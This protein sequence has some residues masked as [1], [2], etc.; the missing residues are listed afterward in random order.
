MSSA[1]IRRTL[2]SVPKSFIP[3]RCTFLSFGLHFS[4]SPAARDRQTAYTNNRRFSSFTR[5]LRYAIFGLGFR[6]AATHLEPPV[7]DFVN[8]DLLHVLTRI[9]KIVN[10]NLFKILHN[11]PS[12]FTSQLPLVVGNCRL[13]LTLQC[14]LVHSINVLYVTMPSVSARKNMSYYFK[15]QQIIS[16]VHLVK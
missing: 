14:V 10:Q 3:S 5:I 8:R 13:N 1:C 9:K 12:H 6:Q 7:I 4:P 16:T 2:L 15:I 11:C